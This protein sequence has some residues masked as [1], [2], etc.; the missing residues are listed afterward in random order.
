MRVYRITVLTVFFMLP[1]CF[2]VFA[3]SNDRIDELLLQEPARYDSTAYLVLAAGGFIA[4][5]DTPEAAFLK[6]QEMGLAK[7]ELT[8][9]SPVRADEL[10]F[11]LMKSLSL[12]GG[13][14]YG[15]FPGRRY[16]Y[17]EFAFYKKINESGGPGRPVNGD[18]VVRTLGYAFALKGGT[19]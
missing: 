15:F 8:P 16:A 3:Q 5:T 6:A 9:D 14:M 10:T 11:M 18:E 19:K 17:R 12:K 13:I 7:P 2:Q 4:E 1:L